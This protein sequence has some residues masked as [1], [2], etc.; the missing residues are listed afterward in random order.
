LTGA[1]K[2]F[3][4]ER[5]KSQKTASA[6]V[7]TDSDLDHE[8]VQRIVGC[9]GSSERELKFEGRKEKSKRKRPGFSKA[10][11]CRQ[12]PPSR[13]ELTDA[14]IKAADLIVQTSRGV[15]RLGGGEKLV[16]SRPTPESEC[17]NGGSEGRKKRFI[18]RMH[19]GI[20]SVLRN[21]AGRRN[22]EKRRDWVIRG[23]PFVRGG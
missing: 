16:F 5:E 19:L 9:C 15:R 6:V 18:E 20:T 7:K 23:K 4:K 10:S 14:E 8:H 3:D 17:E 1:K 11:W 2:A 22:L 13:L 12:N 21:E